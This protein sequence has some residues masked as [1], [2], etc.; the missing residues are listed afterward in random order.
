MAEQRGQSRIAEIRNDPKPAT[1]GTES[2]CKV[3]AERDG[4]RLGRGSAAMQRL[5]DAVDRRY[6]RASNRMDA[7]SQDADNRHSNTGSRPVQITSR[8]KGVRWGW[9]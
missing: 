2:A 7:K 4:L 6:I 8:G 3:V 1:L 9:A 5:G